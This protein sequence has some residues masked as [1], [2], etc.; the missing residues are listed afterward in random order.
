MR[1][2]K[3]R[4]WNKGDE[5]NKSEMV[6][7]GK[8]KI[9]GDL[10]ARSRRHY[11][12]W[13]SGWKIMQFTGLKD[14]NGKEIYEGDIG[15]HTYYPGEEEMGTTTEKEVVAFAG[16]QFGLKRGDDVIGFWETMDTEDD[17]EIIGNIYE[18]KDLLKGGDLNHG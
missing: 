18:N 5:Y 7:F 12:D 10:C 3:F 14:K 8:L 15:E 11:P 1:T 9:D 16:G 2:I 13:K 17:F 6:Y 4:A